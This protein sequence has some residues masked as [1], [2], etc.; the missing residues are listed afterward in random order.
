MSDPFGDE[1][2]R[3]A[4]ATNHRAWFRRWGTV[5][6]VAGVELFLGRSEAMVWP[7]RRLQTREQL[8]EILARIRRER[9]SG[10]GWWSLGADPELGGALV[11]RGFGW[12]WQPHWMALELDYAKLPEPRVAVAAARSPYAEGLPYAYS[13][14]HG[15]PDPP[16]A[17][18]LGVMS[19]GETVGHVAVNPWRG[20]A[21]IYS[22]GVAAEHRRRGLG[23]A[24]TL[25]ACRAAAENGCTHAVLNATDDGERVYRRAGFRSLGWGQSWWWR[26]GPVPTARQTA[27]AEA[28]GNGDLGKLAALR[29]TQSELRRPLPG[30]TSPLR[31]AVLV[32]RPAVVEL[33]LDRAPGLAR[34]R[35]E[36]FGGT[37][38]HVA[39]EWGRT[40]IARLALARDVDP[41]TRDRSFKTTPLSWAKH[42]GN[43]S[44]IA[45]LEPLTER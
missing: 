33:M 32:D 20:I 34:A 9:V 6:V 16:G 4:I 27:L 19:G 39:V 30:E 14:M 28:I 22:M 24:L 7:V 26:P 8:D 36:P 37:L 40:D 45:L 12:G 35:V 42:F 1:Q 31:L 44:L 13:Y 15:E 2:L 29:P 17:I 18:H 10:A 25:A 5:D 43:D 23:L 3:R 21:G 38:L 41:N 11:G